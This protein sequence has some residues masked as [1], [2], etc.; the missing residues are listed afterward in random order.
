MVISYF[1]LYFMHNTHTVQ[2]DKDSILG[3][4]FTGHEL[5][6]FNTHLQFHHLFVFD[7]VHLWCCSRHARPLW[8]IAHELRAGRGVALIIRVIIAHPNPPRKVLVIAVLLDPEIIRERDDW[9]IGWVPR[10][11][12]HR[13]E[14]LP[15]VIDRVQLGNV[16]EV[17]GVIG[18]IVGAHVSANKTPYVGVQIRLDKREEGIKVARCDSEQISLHDVSRREAL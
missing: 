6:G 2:G 3:C 7:A 11:K 8:H 14:W 12:V 1:T 4:A 13:T 17:D 15:A 9:A 16:A 10:S 18:S 5:Y